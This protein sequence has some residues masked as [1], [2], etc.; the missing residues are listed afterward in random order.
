MKNS[1]EKQGNDMKKIW[2]RILE[3]SYKNNLSHIGSCLTMAPILYKVYSEKKPEDKVILSAGHSGLALYVILEHF[4]RLILPTRKIA[5]AEYL[6]M[7]HGVHPN[8]DTDYG[9]WMSS[10][11]LGHGLGIGLGMALA[12]KSRN[13]YVLSTDGEMQEGS[14]YETLNVAYDLNVNNFKLLINCNG[15]GAFKA[16]E[17]DYLVE[18]C[19]AFT[20]VSISF[21]ANKDVWPSYL[22]GQ[23]A[24]YKS[25]NKEEYE[26]VLTYL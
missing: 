8:R 26:E 5:D 2:K 25:L 24:H 15:W 11:S 3:I 18:R 4:G 6:F 14:C 22:Q 1:I 7:K 12:D 17:R 16:L 13:I 21:I 23:E 9:I 19:R 20:N 10:G